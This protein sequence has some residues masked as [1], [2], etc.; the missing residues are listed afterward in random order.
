MYLGVPNPNIL[1]PLEKMKIINR[2]TGDEFTVLYN[3][4]SYTQ[5]KS[6]NYRQVQFMGGDAPLLQF[7]NG[8][9]DTLSVELFFDAVSAGAEVGGGFG[10][11]AKFT[12]N[13]LLPTATS[14]IDIRDYTDEIVSLMHVDNNKHRPPRL[15]LKWASLQYKCFLVDCTQT[16]TRFNE[17]GKPVRA[18]LNCTFIQHVS[19]KEMASEVP[20]HSPDTTK[21]RTVRDK[22]SL[23]AMSD[24]AYGDPGDWRV[25]ADANGIRNP[26]TLH[27]GDRLVLPAIK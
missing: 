8:S 2:D 4:Q 1:M 23:W 13:S 16:F 15:M 7:T 6:A 3:P 24:A 14:L 22:D 18:R 12:A 27:S 20:L 11:K 19:L 9:A 5:H 25:I 17:K 26:R 21:Y 10:D